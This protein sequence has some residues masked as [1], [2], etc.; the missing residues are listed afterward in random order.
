VATWCSWAIKP[1]DESLAMPLQT[2]KKSQVTHPVYRELGRTGLLLFPVGLGAMPLSMRGRPEEER[3][4][5]VLYAA[6]AAN[7]NFIDTAN[8]YCLGGSDIG[9]NECLIQKA[10]EAAGK[11]RAVVVATKGGVDRRQGKVDA[12]PAHLRESCIN[13]LRTLK[14]DTITLY[15]L[16]APDDSI[17]FADSVG[18]LARLKEE[19]KIQHVGLCNVNLA[20]LNAAQAI[21]RIESVQN[22]CNPANPTDY[23]NGLLEAC[24]QQ[25]VSY[26]PHSVIGGKNFSTTIVNHPLF[27]QL[28]KKYDTN[29]YAVVIAW[30]LS[31]SDRVIPIPGASRPDS[32]ISSASAWQIELSAA[33]VHQIDTVH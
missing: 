14:R 25:G 28:G 19:G 5:S 9:H 26:L 23:K 18:E 29:P 20:Q 11:V 8:A 12:S 24:V 10:L 17:P 13:S 4:L 27:V 31:K 1:L 21:V 6:F 7:M 3:A 22:A 30:H 32:A 33:D 16:H 2:P 15:Q